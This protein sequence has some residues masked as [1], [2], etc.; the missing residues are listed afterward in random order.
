MGAFL[1][2][3]EWQSK[4]L[5]I[6]DHVLDDGFIDPDSGFIRGYRETTTGKFWL[7]YKR[8][9]DWFAPGAMAK[10]GY[11]LL[12]FSDELRNDPRAPR[13]RALAVRVAQWVQSHVESTPNG[14]YPRRATPEGKIFRKNPKGA[15]D[16]LWEDS[17][18]GL[19]ILQLDAAL[20]ARGMADYSQ[21]LRKRTDVFMNAG[22]IFGSINQDTFDA[23][24]N[25]AY[26]V[27]FRTLLAASRVLKD[28]KIRTFA[29]AQCLDGLEPFKIREDR[30]GVTTKGLMIMEGSWDTAYLWENA[31]A[32][33]AY[34]EAAKDIQGR[35][36][37]ESTKF[38]IEGLTILRAIAKHHHGPYGFLT[39]GVD[40]NNHVG[41]KHHFDNQLFGDIRYT[42]P[43]LNNQHIAEPTLYYLKNLARKLSPGNQTEWHDIEGNCILRLP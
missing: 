32:A 4:A 21:E 38:Q 1:H 6:L 31:E 42:E 14:W 20:T 40:W 15:D 28:D 19:Y 16:I 35:S 27:A 2:R 34:F 17:A 7:N 8:N 23:H 18:D 22:G 26:S 41:Q 39:E 33:L 3:P 37:E 24:E 29:Y 36:P 11:Q 13:M 9:N 5:S 25:V 43:F 10:V 12:I 30:N